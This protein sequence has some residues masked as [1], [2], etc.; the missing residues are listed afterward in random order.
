MVTAGWTLC[1]GGTIPQSYYNVSNGLLTLVNDGVVGAGTCWDR[2]PSSIS[3]WTST[4]RAEWI[5]GEYG[6]IHLI[7]TTT[8]HTYAWSVDGYYDEYILQ[9]DGVWVFSSYGYTPGLNVFH[10]LTLDMAGGVLTMHADGAVFGSYREPDSGTNMTGVDVFAGWVSTESFDYVTASNFTAPPAPPPP[11]PGSFPFR[12]N[13][14]YSSMANMTAAGWTECGGAIIPPSYYAVG[15]GLLTLVNDGSVGAGVCWNRIPSGVSDWTS[16]FHGKWVGGQYGTIHLIVTTT[17]HT[18]A[19]SAD[20]YYSRTILQ[21]DGAWVFNA[22]G[23]VPQP[24]VWHTLRL[25]MGS[26]VLTMIFDGRTIGTYT[27]TDPGT[28]ITGIDV[29]AGWVS[30]ETFDYVTAAPLDPITFNGSHIFNGFNVTLSG[31]LSPDPIT[32]TITGT[33]S[34]RLTNS[35][36]GTL[37]FFKTFTIVVKYTASN[38][39]R[40]VMA[41]GASRLLGVYC[42]VNM[43]VGSASCIVARNPD[44]NRDG[45]ITIVDIAQLSYAYGSSIGSARYDPV[46][47]LNGDGQ[48]NI[49]DFSMAAAYYG[50]PIFS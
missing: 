49:V 37:L 4:I 48:I 16:E 5:G 21:R 35:T 25:N 27:E 43:S 15:S 9:R 11:P 14:A 29:F 3:N 7:V 38:G 2:I 1:G 30:T 6:T 23:Y 13:F 31:S 36:T 17:H 33:S 34:V 32:M 47:D 39:A 44:T 18:Y 40:F 46:L 45:F 12:D 19:W 24:G 20:G 26:N 41:A 50:S 10:Q 28:T 42:D 8:H 22:T